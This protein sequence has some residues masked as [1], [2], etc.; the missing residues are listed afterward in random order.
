MEGTPTRDRVPVRRRARRTVLD[1]EA[2]SCTAGKEARLLRD[3]VGPSAFRGA[4]ALK[5]RR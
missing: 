4:A 2:L 1:W 3:L 5:G